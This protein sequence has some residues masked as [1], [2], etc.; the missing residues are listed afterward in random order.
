MSNRSWF[1]TG[2]SLLVVGLRGP[3]LPRATDRQAAFAAVRRAHDQF[4]RLDIIVNNAGYGVSGAIQ[5]LSKTQAR[6]QIAVNLF[7]ALWATRLSHRL[8]GLVVGSR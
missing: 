5:E 8:G 7:G 3:R 6:R 1:I 4:G 2:A